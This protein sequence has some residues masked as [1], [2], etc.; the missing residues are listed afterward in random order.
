MTAT[1]TGAAWRL[2]GAGKHYWP[3]LGRGGPRA[4]LA[5]ITL[6]GAPGSLTLLAGPNGSGKSTLLKILASVT[7][8]DSGS[9][10]ESGITTGYLPE[11]PRFPARLA[12]G[13]LTAAMGAVLAPPA[14][15]AACERALELVGL[16]LEARTRAGELSHGQRQRLGLALALV[17]R[18]RLLLLDEPFNGLDPHA[19]RDLAGVLRDLRTAGVTLVVSSHLFAPFDGLCDQLVILMA[20]RVVHT[21]CAR[22]AM[23]LAV[24]EMEAAYF[25]HVREEAGPSP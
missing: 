2:T 23:G 4:A 14:S 12:V 22:S 15:L 6:E 16:V 25:T 19:L 3:A 10:G 1:G 11:S 18:P 9:A 13:E 17:G 5:G 21:M 24:P 7:S 8:P 20:G